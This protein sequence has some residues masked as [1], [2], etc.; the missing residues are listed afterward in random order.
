MQKKRRKDHESTR[1][2]KYLDYLMTF[3]SNMGKINLPSTVCG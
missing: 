1:Q 3:K 2:G